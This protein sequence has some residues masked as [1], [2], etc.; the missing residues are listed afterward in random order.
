ME[1]HGEVAAV[2]V[3]LRRL[4]EW[5]AP[6]K[7]LDIGN[8]IRVSRDKFL[9]SA[10]E[11]SRIVQLAAAQA[12]PNGW[13]IVI[14][15]ADDDCP[16]QLQNSISSR[17]NNLGIPIN[18][19]VIIPNREFESWFIASAEKLHGCRGF[20]LDPDMTLSDPDSPRNA[21]GWIGK[22]MAGG[23]HEVTDQPAFCAQLS[24]ET[25]FEKSRSFQKMVNESI[26]MFRNIE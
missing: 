25:S 20:S 13:V 9:N 23:Y 15:D 6:Y 14:L 11:F 3:L 22:Q 16:V 24:L 19:S 1:G 17:I 18:P 8:P 2:P 7:Y 26:R 4:G 5:I 12:L 10:V 21:K